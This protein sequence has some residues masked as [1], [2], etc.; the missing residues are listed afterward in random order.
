MRTHI[1]IF[2]I[3]IFITVQAKVIPSTN[4][5]EWDKAGY[6]SHGAQPQYFV[7]VMDFGA[8]ADGISDDK[9]AINNAIASL[10]G[11][12]GIV[13]FPAGSYFLQSGIDL[14]DSVTIRGAGSNTTFIKINS[15]GKCFGIYGSGKGVYTRIV[16]G[17][18]KDSYK[19]VVKDVSLFKEDDYVEIRQDNGSW[20]VDQSNAKM[21]V[22]GQITKIKYLSGDT[23]FLDDKLR[24]NFD[25]WLNPEIQVINPKKQISIEYLNIERVNESKDAKGFNIHFNYAVNC[26][27]LGIESNKSQGSHCK[28]SLSSNIE[29]S[30]SYFHDAIMYD[31][32]GTKGYGVTID[33]H[34][35]LCLVSNNIFKHLRHAM[36]TKDGANGNVFAYNYSTDVYRNGKGE[37]PS[38]FAGDISLHGHYSY[39]NLFESNIVQNL[40]IDD[41]NGPSG[42]YNTFFRNR[43]EHYGIFI[44]SELTNNSNCVGNEIT[45]SLI[46]GLSIIFGS[47][48]F[49]YG[50][51][52]NG[53][54]TPSGSSELNDNSYYLS[55]TPLFWNINDRWPSI[56]INNMLN[57]GTIPAQKR[58]SE[59]IYT[60]AS[61][62]VVNVNVFKKSMLSIEAYPNPA[63]EKIIV[64]IRSLVSINAIV[65]FINMSGNPLTKHYFDMVQIG[66]N[67]REYN[68]SNLPNGMCIIKVT[69][70]MGSYLKKII[71]K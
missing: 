6:H 50:N 4:R 66:N 32:V 69:T 20:D 40:I 33:C 7:N 51:N 2:L 23:L 67:Q 57:S 68:I 1:F 9:K 38:D 31:G 43:I 5:V 17:F 55:S 13:Y 64:C 44:V 16:S 63:D 59:G 45:G 21:K 48:N 47:K 37:Y 53:T 25:P 15:T 34:S 22:V 19:I 49:L 52:M 35:G 71:V 61:D 54:I 29:I 24:L 36:M 56:G 26:R 46:N 42:P 27:V 41:Y 28:I 62:D 11:H 12:Y 10:N 18:N 70:E 3:A 14:P 8:V 58:Y 60:V 39:A 65:T 30:G